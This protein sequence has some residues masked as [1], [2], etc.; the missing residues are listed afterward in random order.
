M[1]F[2][3]VRRKTLGSVQLVQLEDSDGRPIQPADGTPLQS[4]QGLYRVRHKPEF[5]NWVELRIISGELPKDFLEGA[6]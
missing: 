4:P 2:E 5:G 1:K 3:I 6:S